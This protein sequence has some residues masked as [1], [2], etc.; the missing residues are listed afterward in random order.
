[1]P[2]GSEKEKVGLYLH[3]IGMFGPQTGLYVPWPLISSGDLTA[4]RRYIQHF[5][6]YSCGGIIS[7]VFIFYPSVSLFPLLS[8]HAESSVC[9]NCLRAGTLQGTKQRR[10]QSFR[11]LYSRK[12]ISR[13]RHAILKRQK[14]ERIFSKLKKPEKKCSVTNG[15]K[16]QMDAYRHAHCD[17]PSGYTI[18]E[19][20][21]TSGKRQRKAHSRLTLSTS[22]L[23]PT[24]SWSQWNVPQNQKLLSYR[25]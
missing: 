8:I 5:S 23:H 20:W 25:Q 19:L 4:V 11:L 10:S 14:G 2:S 13:T 18:L 22:T 21:Y 24:P 9:V 16:K 7:E 12:G 15:V 17:A 6:I 3:W 1:M